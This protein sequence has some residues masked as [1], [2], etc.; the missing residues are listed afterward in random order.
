MKCPQCQTD[1]PANVNFCTQCGTVLRL[2]CP[3]CGKQVSSE[4]KFCIECGH[5]LQ[6]TQ[7]AKARQRVYILCPN[8]RFANRAGI[9]FCENCGIQISLEPNIYRS[10]GKSRTLSAGKIIGQSILRF[11]GGGL[12]SFISSKLGILALNYILRSQQ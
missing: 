10:K 6:G 12:L 3:N 7:P 5:A 4:M 11:V 1:N 2:S 9:H 8:C